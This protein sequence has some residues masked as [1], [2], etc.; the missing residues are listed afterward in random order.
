MRKQNNVYSI[1]IQILLIVIVAFLLD[2]LILKDFNY[3]Y[4]FCISIT[5]LL[6]LGITIV[7]ALYIAHV[8]EAGREQKQAVGA[9]LG[10]MIQSLLAECDEIQH[11]VYDN[12]LN[13]LQAV[14]FP[15]KVYQ[16]CRNLENV[17]NRVGLTCQETTRLL[18]KLSHISLLKKLLSEITYRADNPDDYL[19]VTGN[20]ICNIAP[21]RVGKI[22]RKIADVKKDLYTL[23][24]E[25]SLNDDL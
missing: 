4:D 23:W 14:A 12:R 7:L 19:E 15:K 20:I 22:Q 1:I 21:A 5:E 25:I 10:G 3:T 8:V 13:Y 18:T 24:V 2:A 11:H 6:G 17:M 9:I 16:F